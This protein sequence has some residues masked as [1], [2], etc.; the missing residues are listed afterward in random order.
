M[1]ISD[2]QNLQLLLLLKNE[3]ITNGSDVAKV[4]F[5]VN[6]PKVYYSKNQM[7]KT[8]TKLHH[9]TFILQLGEN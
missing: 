5:S 9:A 6:Y 8:S 7:T 1:G 3:I 4:S 2:T